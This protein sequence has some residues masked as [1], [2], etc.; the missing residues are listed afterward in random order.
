[1]G[2]KAQTSKNKIKRSDNRGV[3]HKAALYQGTTSVVPKRAGTARG[4][5]GCGKTHFNGPLSALC[6]RARLHS[7][8]KNSLFLPLFF[9][10]RGF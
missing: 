9:P 3:F 10:S 8:V 5:T 2:G 6:N 4:F 7:L 1:M